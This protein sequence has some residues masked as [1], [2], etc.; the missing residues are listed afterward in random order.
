MDGSHYATLN[1]S[2]K[3]DLAAISAAATVTLWA[4]LGLESATVPAGE[5]IEPENHCAGDFLYLR[6]AQELGVIDRAGINPLH[7][8][9]DA[10][11]VLV[12]TPVAQMPVT[13]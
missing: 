13:F 1:L 5:V 10:D 7:E 12:A 2:D 3:S 11:I 9:E 4:Y 8:I 6:T